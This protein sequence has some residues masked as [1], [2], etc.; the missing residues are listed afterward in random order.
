LERN[1][2]EKKHDI[3]EEGPALSALPVNNLEFLVPET[4][5][6][7]PV[8]RPPVAKNAVASSLDKGD[9]QQKSLKMFY[10]KPNVANGK[11]VQIKGK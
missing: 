5:I 10:F 2:I 8:T 3:F 7:L 4:P 6:A 1:N 9:W 11:I